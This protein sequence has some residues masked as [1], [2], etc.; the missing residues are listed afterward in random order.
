M[1]QIDTASLPF[2]TEKQRAVIGH[3][4]YD[5]KFY[6][7]VA[8]KLEPQWFSEP[9]C[10]TVYDAVRKWNKRWGR[11]PSMQE[12]LESEWLNT[13]KTAEVQQIRGL[14]ALSNDLRA[15]YSDKPLLTEMEA[16]MKT[17]LI[18]I[19]LPKAANSYNKRDV[20]SAVTTLNQMVKEFHSIRF[21]EDGAS[22]FENYG[23]DRLKQRENQAQKACTFGLHA[24]DQL[25]QKH[26]NGNPFVP[27][28]HTVLLAPANVGKT[29]CLVTVAV[30][31]IMQGKSV[32]FIIHEG[33]EQELKDKFMSSLT[34][35]NSPELDR[36]YQDPNQLERMHAYEEV[37]RRF[38][39]LVPAFKPGLTVEEVAVMVERYQ[40]QRRISTGKGFDLLVDDYPAKLT[41]E[42]A[43]GGH[44]QT[45]HVQEVVYNYFTQMG[46]YHDLH[47]LTV[48]QTNRDGSKVNR[49]MGTHSYETRLLHM[50]D[51]METWGVMTTAATVITLNRSYEDEAA[52][53][54]VF[55]IAKS[56]QGE[57]GWA[58]VANTD[59]D[60]CRTHGDDMGAF[61]YKGSDSLGEQSAIIMAAH[62]NQLVTSDK[63]RY[64][65][66]LNR[67]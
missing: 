47:V 35:M 40:D 34:G 63:L 65:Q 58:I 48:I 57:T 39:V 19:A 66:E 60:R 16:W 28:N 53:R 7:K 44:M 42:T 31:N 13:Q 33:T 10:A 56:R 61:W 55:F 21:L 24:I 59:Y 54:I 45:R 20:D 5:D 1:S 9:L 18:Q 43:R 23:Q 29:T 41:T 46:L 32:L 14:V 49:R 17:R 51:V 2:S 6:S 64:F 52:N 15:A 3:I 27:G 26:G 62:K 4:L 38:L 12:L 25:V 50:E 11:K 36:A 30:A 37:L 67:L 8:H 22:S